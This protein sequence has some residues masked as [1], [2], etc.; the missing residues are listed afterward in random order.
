MPYKF[1]LSQPASFPRLYSSAETTNFSA[2]AIAVA[3]FSMLFTT[4]ASSSISDASFSSEKNSFSER[5]PRSTPLNPR[6]E[7]LISL[8]SIA[9]KSRLSVLMLS[10]LN[11]VKSTM[12][13]PHDVKSMCVDCVSMLSFMRSSM[14]FSSTSVSLSFTSSSS[15]SDRST[16]S[17]S[18]KA[19]A[20]CVRSS[21]VP[22][23]STGVFKVYVCS[24]TKLVASDD[25]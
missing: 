17:A 11:V 5:P 7:R 19:A 18:F 10:V 2:W 22:S 9:S 1:T 13:S 3:L 8:K 25:A 12:P 15:I 24:D 16:A 23:S 14:R 21:A 4:L 6:S 20:Y